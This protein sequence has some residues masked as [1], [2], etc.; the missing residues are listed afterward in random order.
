MGLLQLLGNPMQD[1]TGMARLMFGAQE[2]EQKGRITEAEIA[3]MKHQQALAEAE[4]SY[5][6][7][8]LKEQ[9]LQA[10]RKHQ[11]DLKA[12]QREADKAKREQSTYERERIDWEDERRKEARM[13]EVFTPERVFASEMLK[14]IMKNPNV[15]P[16]DSLG[17]FLGGLLRLSQAGE[18]PFQLYTGR[19]PEETQTQQQQGS[20]KSGADMSYMEKLAGGGGGG[21]FTGGKM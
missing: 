3:N 9:V 12:D 14:I 7:K 13:L 18:S 4:A 2:A 21:N 1:M 20:S 11:L 17:N 6:A 19:A 5:R 10:Q 15:L 8:V 16:A